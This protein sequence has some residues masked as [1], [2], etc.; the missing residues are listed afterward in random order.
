MNFIR[1]INKILA[2]I[3]V[4]FIK[5]YQKIL[6]PDLWIPSLWLKGKVC[7]HTPHC[8][9]YGIKVL[10]RYWFIPWIFMTMERIWQCNPLNTHTYDP[11][12]FKVVFFSS[13]P[14]WV[15]FLKQLSQDSRFDVVWVVT[16]P[17]K[18]VWRWLQIQENIIKTTAKQIWI[19]N[20][21][22]P[23]KINPDKSQDWKDFA[24]WLQSLNADFLVVIAYGKIMPQSIL[25]IAKVWPINVHGS[26]LPK[27]RWASPIQS[28][29]LNWDNKTWITIMLMNSKM[30]E[31]DML[32]KLEFEIPFDWTTLDII[33]KFSESWPK[34]LNDTIWEYGKWRLSP[35]KQ[36]D[37]EATY[38][39]KIEKE[40]WTINIY[41]ENLESIYNKYRAFYLWPK[42]WFSMDEHFWNHNWQRVI[43]EKIKINHEI[44]QQKKSLPLIDKDFN[45]NESII[46]LTVKPEGKKTISWQ[47]FKQGYIN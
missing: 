43:I 44:Y 40:D 14:I 35:I 20:I 3:F 16:A 19:T 5:I 24:N 4:L 47:E 2:K 8:S 32:K 29:F 46:E 1:Y 30:D 31:W 26:L 13:A 9:E 11:D 34:F 36:D 45:L 7:I 27:Y 37:N 17:D 15:N 38:C 18:P 25:D 22:T 42:I 12:H 28:I 6:S 41:N 23:E 33:N 39:Q 21:N 10:N